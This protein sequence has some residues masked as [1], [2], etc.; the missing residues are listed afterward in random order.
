MLG[1][2]CA[3]RAFT[4]VELLVVIGLIALL[5][6]LLMPILG[7]A[8]Q[9]ARRSTCASNLSQMYA[10]ARQYAP[11]FDDHLPNLY[12]GLHDPAEQQERYRESY[13]SVNDA[14][15]E[16]MAA[17][18][19]LLEDLDFAESDELFYCPSLP[20]AYRPGGT[21]NPLDEEEY[22]ES[23]GYAYNCWP[24][25]LAR[26]VGLSRGRISNSFGLPRPR[27][28]SALLADR[29]ENSLLLPHA[30]IDRMNV[31]FWEGSV[32]GLRLGDYA[33]PWNTDGAEEGSRTFG[34][35]VGTVGVRDT[36]ASL[37]TR[38]R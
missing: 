19:L 9:F 10:A 7:R 17:G 26:P 14:G 34:D 1:H 38:R 21:M 6:A 3:R 24:A 11:Y 25:G 13:Y 5:A 33:I 16:P 23:V 4:L 8:S 30:A 15:E 12:N 27:G 2:G 20:G 36:W 37:S 35:A 32:Q 22:P 29:F 31:C 18:L 28:F